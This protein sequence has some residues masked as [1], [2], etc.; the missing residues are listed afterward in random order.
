M[1][2]ARNVILSVSSVLLC[3]SLT[4]CGIGGVSTP[5]TLNIAA[6]AVTGQVMGGQQPVYHVAIQLYEVGTT[7]YGSASKPLLTPNTV[8]T[9]AYGNFT[10]PSFTCDT[11]GSLVYLT[12]TGGQPYI[13]TT[14]ANLSMMVG[15]GACSTVTSQ[16]IDVNEMTTIATVWSLA[17]FMTG[18]ANIGSS[19]TNSLGIS[20]AFASINKV[21]NTATGAVSGPALPSNATLPTTELNTLAD[22]LQACINSGGGSASDTTDGQT[23]GTAC[24]KLFYLTGGGSGSTITDTVTA[25]MK[26][27]QNPGTN[28]TK[29]NQLRASSPTFTPALDVNSPP[30]DWTIAISYTGGGLN[31]PQF[32]ATDQQG[33]VWVANYGYT[34][35]EF[36]PTGAAISTSAGFTGGGI[37]FP[38]AFAIDPSGNAW[39]ANNGNNSITKIGPAGGSLTKYMNNGLDA[40]YS[41][42]ID[43][44]GNVFVGSGGNPTISAFNNSGGALTGSPFS[45]GGLGRNNYVAVSPK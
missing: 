23:N 13:G 37:S 30:N 17:P 3:A 28:V 43:A 45:G 8:Y 9:T 33:N 36:G 26:I 15:L 18:I 16:F 34:V 10:L 19:A 32:V 24:G 40:P 11:P 41:I 31:Y 22:I 7:G 4:G 6:N 27:A 42:A 5:A 35:S 39:V 29:L 12:A 38:S 14:N 44:A 25:A 2:T 20:N 21:A 1:K